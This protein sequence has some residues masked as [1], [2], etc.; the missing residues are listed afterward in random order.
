MNIKGTHFF[1]VLR[2]FAQVFH[3]KIVYAF[4]VSSC[5]PLC[6]NNFQLIF[7]GFSLVITAKM[8][9][10]LDREKPLGL[11]YHRS[12][13]YIR[14]KTENLWRDNITTK[15]CLSWVT[16]TLTEKKGD[17]SH[18][19]LAKWLTLMDSFIYPN[20]ILLNS[21]RKR[22]GRALLSNEPRY[23]L[24]CFLLSFCLSIC[25]DSFSSHLSYP[26]ALFWD[27]CIVLKLFGRLI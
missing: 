24:S 13:Y 5:F 16:F 25:F 19:C 21:M 1:V 2:E 17:S 7:S 15:I 12:F 22:S 9:Q 8:S 23:H 6:S 20:P 10:I 4:H 11:S 3:N 27:G 14:E 26:T 18:G